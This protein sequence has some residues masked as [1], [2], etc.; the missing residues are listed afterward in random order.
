MSALPQ[1][2]PLVGVVVSAGRMQRAV[3]IRTTKQRYNTFLRKQYRE[4]PTHL[5]SD[6][7]DSLRAGD[8]VRV[9]PWRTSKL[10]HHVV[11]EIVA[12]FGVPLEQRPPVPRLEELE[13]KRA[14][15][16]REKTARRA[17]R[18]LQALESARARKAGSKGKTAGKGGAATADDNTTGK[19]GE[20]RSDAVGSETQAENIE[21]QA[22]EEGIDLEKKMEGVRL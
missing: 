18:A 4:H 6:P 11:S 21:T 1:S 9:V 5:V 19:V 10:I 22:R 7:R 12:P 3:K 13:A 16:R 8:I 15:M 20:R 17:A 2:R 14:E